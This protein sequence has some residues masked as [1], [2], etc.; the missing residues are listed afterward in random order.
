MAIARR[1]T[2]GSGC[3]SWLVVIVAFNGIRAVTQLKDVGEYAIPAILVVIG[4]VILFFTVRALFN[5]IRSY[6]RRRAG[7]GW[8]P[9]PPPDPRNSPL[10]D[11]DLD[12]WPGR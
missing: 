8:G 7:T 1:D 9:G 5:T 3:A 11:R 12:A 2:E 10:Y 6:S 4:L